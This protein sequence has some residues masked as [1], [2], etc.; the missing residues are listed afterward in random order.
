MASV[1][2]G[3]IPK[4][5]FEVCRDAIGAIILL[6]LTAQKALQGN[7][8]FPE[9]IDGNS[10]LLESLIPT[11]SA[12]NLTINVLLDSTTYTNMTQSAAKGMTRYFVDLHVSGLSSNES[13]FRRDKF[14]GMIAYIFRSAQYRTLGLP[15]TAGLIGGVYVDNFATQ[16]PHKKEDSDYTSFAR[17]QISVS[18]QEDADVWASVPL[19]INNTVVS[20]EM[21][22]KGYIFVFDN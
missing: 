10:V 5:G 18:I 2:T 4:Q 15:L 8:A 9:T 13:A 17:L 19:E 6:E 7:T 11:D 1:L 3:I 22:D 21:S 12:N 16:D 20:L 14:I